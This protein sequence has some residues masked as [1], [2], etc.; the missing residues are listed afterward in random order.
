[1]AA[2]GV[3]ILEHAR[4]RPAPETAGRLVRAREVASGDSMLSLYEVRM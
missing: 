4:K 1:M 3:L 2:D